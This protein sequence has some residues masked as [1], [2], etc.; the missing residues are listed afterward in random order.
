[1]IFGATEI[2]LIKKRRQKEQKIQNGKI[3]KKQVTALNKEEQV[4]IGI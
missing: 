4:W 1:M 2:A 3:F